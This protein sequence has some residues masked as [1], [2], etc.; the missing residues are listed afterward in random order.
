M[1]NVPKFLTLLQTVGS[2]LDNFACIYCSSTDRERHLCMFF[3]KLCLWNKMQNANILHI[4]PEAHISQRINA[5]SPSRYVKGDLC[6]SEIMGI[7]KVD[8]TKIQYSDNMFDFVICNHVLEHVPDYEKALSEI[9]RV[10]R[11]NGSAVLQTPYSK[12][13]NHNFEEENINTDRL[14]SFFY[15]QEDHVRLFSERQLLSD[16]QRAGFVLNLQEHE[17]LFD[18]GS[19]MFYGVNKIEDLILVVKPEV[20][21][22]KIGKPGG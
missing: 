8:V 18:D 21:V 5:Q 13:L 16:L 12:V 9:F 20:G 11:T 17:A 7:N 3:D 6:P 14:R 10:L 22:P 19:S 2:D 4:A 1:K 15:G